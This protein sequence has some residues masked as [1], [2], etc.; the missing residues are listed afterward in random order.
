MKNYPL[1]KYR[2]F[3]DGRRVIAISTYAGKTVRG[4]AICDPSD[5]FDIEK[6]KKL[7]ATRCALKIAFKR[8]TRAM[9]KVEEA[10]AKVNNAKDHL[11][12]MMS[13]RSD[14]T[15]QLLDAL[16]NLNELIRCF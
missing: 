5:E 10:E 12:R 13:Y 6:G 14:A 16:N 8:H 9:N 15:N 3:V 7:A 11:V 1:E 4:V 2:Y